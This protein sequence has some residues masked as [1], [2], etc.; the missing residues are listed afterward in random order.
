MSWRKYSGGDWEYVGGFVWGET[1]RRSKHKNGREL[2]CEVSTEHVRV[3]RFVDNGNC[4]DLTVANGTLIAAAPDLLT[5]CLHALSHLRNKTASA[6]TLEEHRRVVD[7]L[8]A[9]A[10]KKATDMKPEDILQ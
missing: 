1:H 10:I 9:I 8:L 3:E 2:I 6:E 7:E 5:A 4:D